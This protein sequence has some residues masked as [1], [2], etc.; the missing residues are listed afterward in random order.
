MIQQ[1]II[2]FFILFICYI[3]ISVSFIHHVQTK[4]TITSIQSIQNGFNLHLLNDSYAVCLDGTPGGFYYSQGDPSL[5]IIE[6][7]GG[8]W[9]VSPGDCANRAATAIGSS[10]G[11][12][13]TTIPG[14]DGGANG[15]FSRNCTS[16]PTFCNATFSLYYRG[17]YIFNS[18]V[19]TILEMGMK[20]ATNIILKGCSAGGLATYL[21]TDIFYNR[22]V[23][24][25]PNARVVAMPDAGFFRDHNNIYN[26]PYYSPLYRWVF[27]TMNVTQTN[28][29]CLQYYANNQSNC[30]F[31]EY[32]LPFITAPF[33]V[34]QDL[35]DSWQLTNIL[36]LP[37]EPYKPGS[38]NATM[39]AAVA[40]Y[41]TS[42]LTALTPLLNNPLNGAFLSSCVQHCHQNIDAV[43]T[44]EIVQNQTE[45]ET[46]VAWWTGDSSLKHQ[47]VD[48][49]FGTN[50]HCQGVPYETN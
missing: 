11:W 45:Q 8:G 34:T 42:M 50:T 43:W 29:S 23:T 3:N 22:M 47:V 14:M 18:S 21:H 7:E 33:F 24:D 49:P 37:C 39:L 28:P 15:M 41:R 4:D 12:P 38:C 46:F 30:F 36:Q 13:Q 2:L 25:A 26:E 19:S 44:S 6:L 32:V 1:Q 9:C 20:N 40:D 16:N 5:Y 35:V 31:A 48:G 10:K 27:D 17:A